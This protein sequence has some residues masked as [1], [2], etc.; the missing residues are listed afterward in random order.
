VVTKRHDIRALL[1]SLHLAAVQ[2][3]DPF[4]RTRDAVAGWIDESHWASGTRV[5]VFA[6]GKAGAAMAAGAVDAIHTSHLELAGGIAVV[7]AKIEADA[8]HRKGGA[9]PASILVR[10]G[11][12]PVPELGSL[13]AS[14]AIARAVA[15]ADEGEIALV[16]ISGGATSLCAAPCAELGEAFDN[17]YDVQ[18]MVARMAT[19]L[20]ESGLTIHEMNMVRRRLL[21]WAAGRLAVALYER[22]AVAIPTFAIS[23]VIGDDPAVI[24][25]GPCSPDPNDLAGAL[26]V[27]GAMQLQNELP[28]ELAVALGLEGDARVA[29]DT[30]RACHPA[31][32]LVDW[33]I[34][35]R[36]RDA[37]DAMAQAAR[38]AGISDVFVADV[39]MEGEAE[40]LGHAIARTALRAAESSRDAALIVWGGEPIVRM[41]MTNRVSP[42]E[43]S[44]GPLPDTL[45]IAASDKP[46]RA[47]MFNR[48]SHHEQ[49]PLGGRM[50]ALALA[51]SLA[52][53]QA[54][55]QMRT[56]VES[57]VTIL[58]A[59]TDG[60][61]GPTD[62]CGAIVDGGT[63]DDARRHTRDPVRDLHRLRSYYAL[64]AAGALLRT[65]PTGTNVMD[66][67]AA[68]IAP[69]NAFGDVP[70]A[71]VTVMDNPTLPPRD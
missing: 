8:S 69:A 68:Y 12:H 5:H 41:D 26:A 52:L 47:S 35:A 45:N 24:G 9:L 64:D 16:L 3:A 60:R 49:L 67:V 62:A 18:G 10:V 56:D 29:I 36:N 63:P 66:V 55:Y 28:R 31:F 19:T 22:G 59:G 23:D 34:I 25:S 65:G 33:R 2:G 11:D 20:H 30:P 4:Q 43:D 61:D 7:T 6:L 54:R 14:D 38:D 70:W 40:M 15:A 58:A 53:E 21:R 37:C 32:A 50:Q 51:A 13:A 71:S 27:M 39:P 44:D 1:S 48:D 42:G 57:R 46:P 17:P